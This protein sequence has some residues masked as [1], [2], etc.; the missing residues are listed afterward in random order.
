MR[1]RRMIICSLEKPTVIKGLV[2][3][4]LANL[5]QNWELQLNLSNFGPRAGLQKSYAPWAHTATFVIGF[6]LLPALPR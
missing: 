3:A 5:R 4:H 6:A 1:Q 2:K